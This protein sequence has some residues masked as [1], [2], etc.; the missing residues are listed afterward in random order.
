MGPEL[1]TSSNWLSQ[2]ISLAEYHLPS[3]SE[4]WTN[5]H[6]LGRNLLEMERLAEPSP[7]LSVPQW[8]SRN[9]D[10]AICSLFEAA[11]QMFRQGIGLSDPKRQLIA[12]QIH[13][14]L[15][16]LRKALA[17]PGCLEGFSAMPRFAKSHMGGEYF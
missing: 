4:A 15:R 12:K 17:S 7:H 5:L 16:G 8:D 9:I 1:V 13:A 6:F 11:T 10:Q 14:N 2:F 3:N